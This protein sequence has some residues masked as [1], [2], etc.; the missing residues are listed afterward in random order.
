MTDDTDPDPAA[1]D[2]FGGAEVVYRYTRARAL[3]DGVL[4]ELTGW[5]REAGFIL[6]VACTAGVWAGCVVPD[7]SLRLRGQS[8]QGRAHDLLSALRAAIARTRG[9][10]PAADRLAFDVLFLLPPRQL[11]PVRLVAVCGP[12]DAGEPV[13]TVLLPGEDQPPG[14]A[15]AST[16]PARAG[17]VGEITR[18][19]GD[20]RCTPTPA[21]TVEVAAAARCARLAGLKRAATSVGT[22]ERVY[23]KLD[24]WMRARG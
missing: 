17:R 2:P 10:T 4:V 14:G 22:Y 8:E 24:A 13:L 1:G 18:R 6:P 23:R 7:E 21:G 19:K 9:G 12:G 5:A 3:A 11:V 20:D 16:K 15:L